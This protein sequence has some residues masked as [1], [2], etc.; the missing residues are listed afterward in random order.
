M[1]TTSPDGI[2]WTA[3]ST[4]TTKQLRLVAWNGSTFAAVGGSFVDNVILSSDSGIDWDERVSPV[5]EPLL[6]VA[7]LGTRFIAVG[8]IFNVPAI[9]AIVTSDDGITWTER[10]SPVE[11][12]LNG[13]GADWTPR[14]APFASQLLDAAAGDGGYVIGGQ[15]GPAPRVITATDA[16]FVLRTSVG[17]ETCDLCVCDVNGSG[18]VTASDAL[19]VLRTGVGQPVSLQCP[20]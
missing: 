5:G 6:D 15:V 12:R 11:A 18:S 20:A 19:A 9:P 1:V 8:G 7:V 17:L 3:R 4:P 14:D 10:T 2:S 16:L 13:I